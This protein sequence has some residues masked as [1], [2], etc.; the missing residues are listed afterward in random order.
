MMLI[1]FV[2][3]GILMVA[4]SAPAFA[5]PRRGMIAVAGFDQVYTNFF[6]TRLAEDQL[7]EMAAGISAEQLRMRQELEA[8]ENKF[9]DVR[10]RSM[11]QEVSDEERTRLRR[12]AEENILEMRRLQAQIEEYSETQKKLLDTQTRRIRETLLNEIRAKIS[13]Y[14]QANGFLLVIDRAQ[15]NEQGIPV[16][17]YHDETIDVTADIIRELNR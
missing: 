2:I 1:R 17:L 13:E 5:Q 16:I 15:L 8:R 10:D 4:M 14:A 3:F 9:K 6:K 12:Q 11:Q 7:R